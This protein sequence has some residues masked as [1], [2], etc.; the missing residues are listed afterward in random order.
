MDETK[1][2]PK[3]FEDWCILDLFGHTRIA[4]KVTEAT[5]AG[6]AFL[7]VDI[8]GKDG[9]FVVTQHYG[10]AAIFSITSVSEKVAR[11]F[12]ISHPVVPM[13]KWDLPRNQIELPRDQSCVNRYDCNKGISCHDCE[14]YAGEQDG[15]DHES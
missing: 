14:V 11:A 4:G 3:A 2:E 9:D 5:I 13:T 12:A 10:P 8:P 1:F 7:R 6:G 15:L